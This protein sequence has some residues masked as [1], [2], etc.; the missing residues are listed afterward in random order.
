MRYHPGPKPA[1]GGEETVGL[2]PCS[3]SRWRRLS[4][5]PVAA[6]SELP[7]V[8][9]SSICGALVEGPLVVDSESDRRL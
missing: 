6:A 5:S 8:V 3:A 7:F 2:A 4:H 9:V 1:E